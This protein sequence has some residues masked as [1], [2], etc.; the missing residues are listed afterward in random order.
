MKRLPISRRQLG[1]AALGLALLV[2]FGLV[3]AR[4]GPLAP[5]RV[6]VA[7]VETSSVTPSL[8]GI[9]LVEA[10]R[11]YFI[12]P[13]AAGRVR[14]VGVD[15]GDHVAA[16]QLLAEMDPVDLDERLVS[17]DAARARAQNAIAAAEAQQ[18]DAA[19]RRE[20]A[21]VNDQRYRELGDRRFVSP[22]AVEGRR[23]ELASAAA[24]LDA[25]EANLKGS[26]DELRRL[27]ADHAGLAR[28]RQTLRLLA[29]AAGIVTSR[30]AEPGSTVVAGQ[31]VLRLVEPDSLWFRVRIDQGRSY[32]LAAGIPADVVLRSHPGQRLAG[33]VARVEPVSD[34]ITEERIAFVALDRPFPALSIGELAEVT[35]RGTPSAALPT[36]DNAAVKHT[37]QGAGVWALRNGR[38]EFVPVVPGEAGLD[39]R[40]QIV[41]GLRAG[42]EVIVFSEKALSPGARIKVVDSLAGSRP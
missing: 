22:S 14:S 40:L 39:G 24:A 30:D 19:A 11:A 38:P 4:S 27:A 42:D 26:R 41:E 13:T 9:G 25:A 20:L 23:Q 28:Q 18:R 2:G 15:V 34:G 12:G 8:F 3:V 21:A 31:S 35:L 1:L 36:L 33:R 17:L 37:A 6:T 16:G 10:R 32:G 7:R 5:I 29:P